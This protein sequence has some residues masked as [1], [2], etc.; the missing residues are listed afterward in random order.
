MRNVL[1]LAQMKEI[2]ICMGNIDEGRRFQNEQGF[3]QW[4]DDYPIIDTSKRIQRN[5]ADRDCVY[6]N[7]K[8][9]RPKRHL[10]HPSR[11]RFIMFQGSEK[12]AFDKLLG[13]Q[14]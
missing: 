13:E 1:E 4:T 6:I 10:L 7:R 11:Y 3:T 5:R 9:V 14:K 12:M 2:K 8:T